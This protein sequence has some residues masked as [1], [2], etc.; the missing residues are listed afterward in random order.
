MGNEKDHSRIRSWS[1][2]KT[3]QRRASRSVRKVVSV[4]VPGRVATARTEGRARPGTARGA[5]HTLPVATHPQTMVAGD[6][7]RRVRRIGGHLCGHSLCGAHSRAT[8]SPAP[9]AASDEYLLHSIS[10]LA[11]ACHLRESSDTQAT[12][13][14]HQVRP[15]PGARLPV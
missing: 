2:E 5:P 13:W 1:T 9:A 15:Q 10:S 3:L 4:V 8:L 7:S 12:C 6:W 11:L 14:S